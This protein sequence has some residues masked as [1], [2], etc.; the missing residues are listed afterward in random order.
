MARVALPPVH[1]HRRV[2]GGE[3]RGGGFREQGRLLYF[4][5]SLSTRRVEPRASA[6]RSLRPPK[7]CWWRRGRP[8]RTGNG[9]GHVPKHQLPSFSSKEGVPVSSVCAKTRR[10]SGVTALQLALDRSRGQVDRLAQKNHRDHHGH[11]CSTLP[12]VTVNVTSVQDNR[13]QQR[14]QSREARSRPSPANKSRRSSDATT[15]TPATAM[16]AFTHSGMLPRRR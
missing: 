3:R 6:P 7:E 16:K 15:T 14:E 13:G 9:R 8:A 5:H 2:T 12:A 11:A 1:A 10:F 4:F